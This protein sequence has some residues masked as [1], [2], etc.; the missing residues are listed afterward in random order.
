[1]I[2]S[3]DRQAEIFMLSFMLGVYCA[4]FYAVIKA[5]RIII[6]H[7]RIVSGVEDGVYWAG[8]GLFV[9]KY[10]LEKNNGEIRIFSVMAFFS[11]MLLYHI[12]FGPIIERMLEK[13]AYVIRKILLA[14]AECV[15]MPFKL[16]HHIFR[17][18][19]KKAC[20]KVKKTGYAVLILIKKYVKIKMI[21][22]RALLRPSKK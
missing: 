9:V 20:N 3:A 18:P 12:I 1:M 4:F 22:I 17:R 6:P 19:A 21:T 16:V 11:A 5:I 2:L 10:M 14:A 8:C 7:G 15:A 13:T